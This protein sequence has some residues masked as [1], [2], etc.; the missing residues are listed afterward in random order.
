MPDVDMST[1][2]SSDVNNQ[3]QASTSMASKSAVASAAGP[4]NHVIK[5]EPMEEE[6][7][8]PAKPQQL[9][10]DRVGGQAKMTLGSMA[11]AGIVISSGPGDYFETYEGNYDIN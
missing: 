6:D 11:L 1:L 5:Q 2:V 9:R 8:K 3:N 4:L 10:A 7:I